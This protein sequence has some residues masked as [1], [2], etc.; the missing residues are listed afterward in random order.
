MISNPVSAPYLSVVIPA[1]N[2]YNNISR[3]IPHL[4]AISKGFKVEIIVSYSDEDPCFYKELENYH[5]LSFLHCE[6]KSRAT[7]LNRGAAVAKGDVLI[8]LHADVW[9]PNCFFSEIVS[10][11]SDGYH[12]GLFSYRFDRDDFLLRINS[13]FTKKRGV[14]TGGGDQCLFIR[15]EVFHQLGGF[16][17][18]QVIMED[19]EFFGRLKRSGARYKIVQENL[20]VSARKYESNSYLRVNLS[21]LLL[22]FLFKMNYPS[23]KLRSLHNKLL[24]IPHMKDA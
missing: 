24:H 4:I 21:N 11:V 16:K 14:F 23:R 7:Q 17:E 2:E 5:N 8:F 1:Y 12:A 13:S 20:V 6:K 3:L 9:P 15:E 22:V 19:F 10:T 18:D